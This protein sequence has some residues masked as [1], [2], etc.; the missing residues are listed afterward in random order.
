MDI[1]QVSKRAGVSTAT[2]SR[3]L[4]GSPKVRRQTAERVQRVITDLNYIPNNSARNLRTGRSQMFGLIVSDI[5]NPFF[6]DLIDQFEALASAQNIDVVFTHTNYSTQRLAACIRRLVERNVDGI[7]V[8]TSE[9]DEEALQLARKSRIP[10]VLLNQPTLRA[11]YSNVLVDYSRGYREA[12]EHL[13]RFHHRNIVFL[14][15]PDTLS[16]VRRRRKAFE[17]AARKFQIP[18]GGAH[19]IVGDMQVEGGRAAAE[20]ILSRT[21]RPTAIVAA[22]DLMAIGAM[23]AA[24][25][26]GLRVPQDISILGFDDLPLAT[27]M[28]PKL[29]TIHLSRNQIAMEAFAQLA[30]SLQ[31]RTRN[32]EHAHRTVHPRL[33]VRESTGVAPSKDS[34]KTRSTSARRRP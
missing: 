29:T 9:V 17:A 8:M 7:A 16:S 20:G 12:I 3:V 31:R 10:L 27:I 26:A 4:N 34:A 21:P 25:A 19:M 14:A 11:T 33:V 6:P 30:H 1:Q 18:T 24:A 22:N 2:V 28:H 13:V 23:Q 15:G 32:P 5:K